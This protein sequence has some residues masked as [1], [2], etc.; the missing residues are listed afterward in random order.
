MQL[1][2]IIPAHNEEKR[3]AKMLDEYLPFFTRIYG[4]DFEILTVINGSSDQ[5]AIIAEQY[6]AKF[7]QMKYVVEPKQIGKGGA[8]MLGFSL[9]KG[10]LIGFVDADG[11]T[12]P[13]AFQD[14]VYRIGQADAII[15]SRW[16]KNSQVS[17]CQPW[18]R[19][20]ASR[21]FNG[22]V[23]LFFG[24]KFSDTQCGAKLIKRNTVQ[25]ILP[26]LGITRWAFDV[27]LLFQLRRA[28]YKTIE[29]PTVWHDVSGSRLKIIGAS[30][31]MSAALM[32]LRLLY[33]PFKG[34]V[35]F[36][37]RY[38]SHFLNVQR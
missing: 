23:R 12:P 18:S 17:P 15:A 30:L 13:A 3:L 24:L 5:T 10:T 20:V 26:Q 29:I 2:I 1:T 38:F 37:D 22:I 4:T 28:G 32:R 11:S 6:A 8:I 36:Y 16:L 7:T 14:L 35:S 33:S 21:L 34:I 25:Q 31:E 9:A 19:R 27:D